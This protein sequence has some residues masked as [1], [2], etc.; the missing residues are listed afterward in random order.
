MFGCAN[1]HGLDPNQIAEIVGAFDCASDFAAKKS[2]ELAVG[3]L[4]GTPEPFSR[5]Q[6]EP[7][8]ITATGVV[9][10]PSQEAILLVLH[11]KLGRW[12]LPGGHVEATDLHPSDTA[13]R[14]VLEE[15]GAQLENRGL[16]PLVGIDVHFIPASKR[17]PYHLH[18]DLVYGF[19]AHS[20]DLVPTE[21]VR[22]A[23]WFFLAELEEDKPKVPD[24]VILCAKRAL[25]HAEL[26]TSA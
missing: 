23:A 9:L 19:R 12:L 10:H 4:L 11:R 18:H 2:Q 26:K 17:Q 6:Y 25:A 1:L 20:A 22:E 5:D 16:A 8:H 13:K 14:E 7:G 24:S 21:E 3:L 15:T